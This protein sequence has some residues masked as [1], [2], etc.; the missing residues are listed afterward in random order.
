M[1]SLDRDAIIVSVLGDI[2]GTALPRD[3]FLRFVHET[4]LLDE[5][6]RD[7]RVFAETAARVFTENPATISAALFRMEALARLVHEDIIPGWTSDRLEDGSV[8]VREDLF[9][10]VAET[11]LVLRNG[12]IVFDRD[13]LLKKAFEIG[14]MHSC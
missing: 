13:D 3:E 6:E 12:K 9:V 4:H 1:D 5:D 7:I 11:P 2:N 8:S 10:A 14:R